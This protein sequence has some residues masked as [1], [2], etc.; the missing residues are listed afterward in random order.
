MTIPDTVIPCVWGPFEVLG[1][2]HVWQCSGHQWAVVGLAHLITAMR[3][4]LLVLVP[5]RRCHDGLW[6]V[7]RM[8]LLLASLQVSA[9]TGKIENDW[10][11]VSLHVCIILQRCH[12]GLKLQLP[13]MQMWDN[14]S[15]VL[16]ENGR[17]GFSQCITR[18]SGYTSLKAR[19]ILRYIVSALE[20]AGPGVGGG[21]WL[22]PSLC[23]NTVHHDPVSQRASELGGHWHKWARVSQNFAKSA[24]E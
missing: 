23:T 4:P 1:N 11:M 2:A 21:R 22:W 8:L 14:V 16:D 24:A 18:L 13:S 6:S 17:H 20:S 19:Q 3:G 10:H 5:P 15:W 7:L 9:G 12:H